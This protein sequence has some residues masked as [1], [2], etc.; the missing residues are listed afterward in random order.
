[1]QPII[2]I[3]SPDVLEARISRFQSVSTD[4]EEDIRVDYTSDATVDVVLSD[5][6]APWEQSFHS[7]SRS[8]INPYARMMN[9]SGNPLRDHVGSMVSICLFI[10]TLTHRVPGSL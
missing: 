10:L 3:R 1:M 9:T 7:P 2:A 6:S 5:M 8:L 4:G